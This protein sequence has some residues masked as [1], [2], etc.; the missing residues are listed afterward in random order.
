MGADVDW[1]LYGLYYDGKAPLKLQNPP[2]QGT[3]DEIAWESSGLEGTIRENLARLGYPVKKEN[4][5]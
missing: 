4:S 3:A 2:K 5:P 1:P